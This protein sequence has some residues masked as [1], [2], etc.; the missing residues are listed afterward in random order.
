MATKSKKSAEEK[1]KEENEALK[2]ALEDAK[3]T[4]V[5]SMPVSGTFTVKQ[6]TPGGEVIEK[7]YGFKAGRTKV[8]L[9]T[10]AQVSSEA[11]MR[12]AN[13][14]TATEEEL[15]QYLALQGLTQP[16]AQERLEFLAQ[17]GASFL[18]VRN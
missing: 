2:Q 10:G 17:L 14:G 9:A 4:K 6:E 5:V 7:E 12:I 16:Q 3:T 18:E 8:A 11:L 1:L 15:E 13:G